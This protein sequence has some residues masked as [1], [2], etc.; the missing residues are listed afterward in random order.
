MIFS[1][2]I[3]QSTSNRD[4]EA[5]PNKPGDLAGYGNGSADGAAAQQVNG[6]SGSPAVHPSRDLLEEVLSK[7]G[8]YP[9]VHNDYFFWIID[10]VSTLI[11]SRFEFGWALLR[12]AFF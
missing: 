10:K 3:L 11:K 4:C 6:S 1:F 8:P 9:M 2:S 7:S 12:E 5:T